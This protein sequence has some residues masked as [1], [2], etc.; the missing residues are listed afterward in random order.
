MLDD[1]LKISQIVAAG[2]AVF[3]IFQKEMPKPLCDS[4]KHLLRKSRDCYFKYTCG[5]QGRKVMLHSSP[6]I[7]AYFEES[8]T[9]NEEKDYHRSL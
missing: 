6:E 5:F 8:E 3:M 2:A 9:E 7:C 1:I 4:C